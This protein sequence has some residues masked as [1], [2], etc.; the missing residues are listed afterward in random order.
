M[1][2]TTF[3][4]VFSA[5]HIQNAYVIYSLNKNKICKKTTFLKKKFYSN[6]NRNFSYTIQFQYILL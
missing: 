2:E 5:M 3:A 4:C 6:Y 1:K